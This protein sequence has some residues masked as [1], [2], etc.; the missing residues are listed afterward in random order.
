MT[1]GGFVGKLKPGDWLHLG[2]MLVLGVMAWQGL[3][4]AV[5]QI[6]AREQE[7]YEQLRGDLS[8]LNG[9]LDQHLTDWTLHGMERRP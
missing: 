9:K 7:H 3:K 2:T 4:S 1:N 5:E 8:D 6:T